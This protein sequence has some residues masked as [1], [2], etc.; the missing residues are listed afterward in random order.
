V[1]LQAAF[2]KKYCEEQLPVFLTNIET[3]LKQ[4]KNGD[5]FFVGDKVNKAFI[6][7]RLRPPPGAPLT[8]STSGFI[9][10]QNL[11]GISLVMLVVFCRCLGIRMT[12]YRAIM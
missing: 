11:V 12:C 1:V 5:G 7:S 3:M 9:V 8:M 10:E 4:N 6:D 2:A